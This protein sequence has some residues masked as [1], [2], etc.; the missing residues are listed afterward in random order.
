MFEEARLTPSI[1]SLKDDLVGD[2]QKV[3]W[4]LMGTIGMVLLIAC[5]NVGTCSWSGPS[6]AAGAGDSCRSGA[7]ANRIA[8]ELLL[9]SVTLG[10]LGGLVGLA[11]AFGALKLLVALAPGNLPRIAD[12]AV[13]IPVLV[14]TLVLSVAPACC[15]VRSPCSSSPAP[16][17]IPPCGGGG[18][19]GT[20]SRE[21]HRA[22]NTLV[23]TQVALALVLLVSSGLMIRTFQALKEIDPGFVRPDDV[24][25]FRLSI[26][27]SQVKDEAA[28]ARMHHA[29]MDKVATVPGV[30]SIAL[31]ST[32]TMSGDGW[33]DPIY[34]QDRTYTESEL[35]PIRMFKFVSPGT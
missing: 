24:Q 9:E 18:R 6:P 8:R 2:V 23:V 19:T 31:T 25:I 34:A 16:N 20:A 21:R 27:D 10:I 32:V 30:A 28:V 13:D 33:H 12:I 4:V 29:I 17:S 5:A 26:P 11:L 1:R 22:R 15:L 14:F 3:L 7:G 35:P